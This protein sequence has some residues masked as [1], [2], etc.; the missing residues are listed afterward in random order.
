MKRSIYNI[1]LKKRFSSAEDVFNYYFY[2]LEN[3][4]ESSTY[5]KELREL[6]K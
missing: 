2:M 4:K 6:H 5:S 3:N 1:D